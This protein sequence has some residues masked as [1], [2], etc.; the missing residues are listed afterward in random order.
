MP[1]P[2]DFFTPGP[3]TDPNQPS[4]GDQFSQFLADPR[5][6]AALLQMGLQG[7][8]PP[9]WGD[10]TSGQI[11]RA[12][13]SGGEA[14]GRGEAMDI[15]SQEASS[16]QDLR[17]AQADAATARSG[18]A[19]TTADLAR[20]RL[21][22]GK[23]QEEGRQMRNMLGNR[24]RLSALYQADKAAMEKQ[25]ANPLV[26]PKDRK[27]IPTLDQWVQEKAPFLRGMGLLPDEQPNVPGVPQDTIT[28]PSTPTQATTTAPVQVQTQDEANALPIGTKYVT[29]DGQR[30]T[31]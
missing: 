27:P 24:V 15:R 26:L 20:E 17:A 9:T 29:P 4:I 5:G 21:G 6:R 16:K 14:A 30:F 2:L 28:A 12:V 7:M 18:Q 11:A 25:N 31:R 1:G 10:T 22:L 19:A 23:L 3:W 13:G 8:S